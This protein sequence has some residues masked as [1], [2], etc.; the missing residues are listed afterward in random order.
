MTGVVVGQEMVVLP[1]GPF[2]GSKQKA[3][4]VSVRKG[5]KRVGKLVV[6]SA[7]CGGHLCQAGGRANLTIGA[8]K[9]KALL[10]L[11]F[12]STGDGCSA[13]LPTCHPPKFG[14]GKVYIV[15]KSGGMK[16]GVKS[17]PIRVN[18]G[19]IPT[20]NGSKFVIVLA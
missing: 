7:D 20:T 17:E 18:V 4:I 9:G 14:S 11:S 5:S 15:L 1:N 10:S 19:I 2:A 8:I 12:H 16:I 3:T 6:G 13:G